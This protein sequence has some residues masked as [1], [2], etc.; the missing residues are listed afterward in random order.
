MVKQKFAHLT[1]WDLPLTNI[2]QFKKFKQA[3]YVSAQGIASRNK[4][5]I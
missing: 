5:I 2:D 4:Y 3:T 1:L